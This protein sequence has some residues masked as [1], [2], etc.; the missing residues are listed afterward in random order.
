V[1]S[2]MPTLAGS[3][4]G[5]DR[6]NKT[7]HCQHD[8]LESPP[9]QLSVMGGATLSDEDED[10]PTRVFSIRQSRAPSYPIIGER[11]SDLPSNMIERDVSRSE[12]GRIMF[13]VISVVC[14]VTVIRRFPES[15]YA[16]LP[17][18]T[19]VSACY[20]V[21]VRMVESTYDVCTVP[22]MSTERESGTM[23]SR[24][25]ICANN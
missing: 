6:S 1:N 2:S 16:V 24:T 21:G 18:V 4:P 15:E 17:R 11:H 20:E 5:I 8:S 10:F 12:G 9:A 23:S 22:N 13:P 25:G 19:V 14:G 7:V 3:H